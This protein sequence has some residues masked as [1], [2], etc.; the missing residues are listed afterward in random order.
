MLEKEPFESYLYRNYTNFVGDWLILV[1]IAFVLWICVAAIISSGMSDLK[2]VDEFKT[3]I[4]LQFYWGISEYG[5]DDFSEFDH[6]KLGEVSF[7]S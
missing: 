2:Q 4:D 3:G 1:V 7:D 5:K 6:K